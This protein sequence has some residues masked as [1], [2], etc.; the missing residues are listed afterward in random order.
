MNDES[1]PLEPQST[2]VLIIDVQNDFCLPEGIYARNGLACPSIPALLE[3][4]RDFLVAAREARG[5]ADQYPN[6]LR[7]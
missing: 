7:V 5:A 2:A 4:L 6:R 3:P 1:R